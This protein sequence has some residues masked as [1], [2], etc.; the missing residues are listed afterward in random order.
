MTGTCIQSVSAQLPSLDV[1][2]LSGDDVE[3]QRFVSFIGCWTSVAARWPA[4]SNPGAEMMQC[5]AVGASV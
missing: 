5:V 1:T 2:P 3:F 4:G